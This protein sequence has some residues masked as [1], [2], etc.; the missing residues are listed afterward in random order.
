MLWG[1]SL[2]AILLALNYAS[3][4]DRSSAV[5][6]S[7]E[8][9]WTLTSGG[10]VLRHAYDNVTSGMSV[11]T[12]ITGDRGEDERTFD[13]RDVQDDSGAQ[14]KIGVDERGNQ[15]RC[16]SDVIVMIAINVTFNGTRKRFSVC[17]AI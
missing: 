3:R 1:I 15:N 2:V 13:I 6:T 8:K 7:P 10:K 14:S 12:D 16:G 4:A 17:S 11:M 9:E 5:T